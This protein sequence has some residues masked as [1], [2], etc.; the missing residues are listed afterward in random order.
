LS[1]NNCFF[2]G[3]FRELF[4][5]L[6]PS[7]SPAE[8]TPAPTV[9]LRSVLLVAC[10][11]MVGFALGRGTNGTPAVAAEPSGPII[12]NYISF[13]VK[14]ERREDFLASI[15]ANERDTLSLEPLARA[16]QWG[17]DLNVPNRFHFHEAYAGG[18]AGFQEHLDSEHIAQWDAL[19]QTD[20]FSDTPNGPNLF[21]KMD[22]SAA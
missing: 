5:M 1:E 14:P 7:R 8:P 11:L 16:Y 10:A 3:L 4:I 22:L 12:Y 15:R 13:D 9:P 18:Y 17:E 20:P 19:V 6:E 21:T 2:S